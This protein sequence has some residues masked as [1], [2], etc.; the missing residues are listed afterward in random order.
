M[1]KVV[2]G[3]IGVPVGAGTFDQGSVL[4]GIDLILPFN[5]LD[6]E[7]LIG[8]PRNVAWIPS[9]HQSSSEFEGQEG[10]GG[11]GCAR[12]GQVA[13]RGIAYNA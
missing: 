12:S 3:S 8:V 11:R 9:Q 5:H 4:E 2:R 1:H 7:T 10:E 6:G 13:C